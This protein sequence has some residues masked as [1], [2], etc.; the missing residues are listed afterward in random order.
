MLAATM[1]LI[2]QQGHGQELEKSVGPRLLLVREIGK[3]PPLSS[4]KKTN[5]LALPM[6]CRW[7]T[8]YL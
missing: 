2:A 4:V 8:S 7:L 1:E 5:R 6:A 3:L